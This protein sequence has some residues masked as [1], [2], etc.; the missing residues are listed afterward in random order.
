M[1]RAR[2]DRVCRDIALVRELDA[3]RQALHAEIGR[4]K[5]EQQ[6]VSH[7]VDR[8]RTLSAQIEALSDSDGQS[9][10]QVS[11]PAG[12]R[13]EL[14]TTWEQVC[15]AGPE[16]QSLMPRATAAS[17]YMTWEWMASWYETYG[18]PGRTMC[19]VVRDEDGSAVGIAPLHLSG[20]RDPSLDRRDIGF[21][22]TFG[23]ARASYHE[24][25][26]A[27]QSHETVAEATVEYLSSIDGQWDCAK[28]LWVPDS[29]DVTWYLIAALIRRGWYIHV[30]PSVTATVM[31]LP[32]HEEEVIDALSSRKFAANCRQAQQRLARD[33]PDHCFACVRDS[34]EAVACL[35]QYVN[36]NVVRR[37]GLGSSSRFLNVQYRRHFESSTRRF[38]KA[39]WLR[40]STLRV[41]DRLVG[42][43]PSWLYHNRLYLLSPAW[44]EEYARYQISHQLFLHAI[45]QGI[46]EGAKEADFLSAEQEYKRW[47]SNETRSTMD[48]LCWRSRPQ[49]LTGLAA[50]A[51]RALVAKAGRHLR[52]RR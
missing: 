3:Q 10:A 14:L 4:L 28:F 25:V 12:S 37:R 50:E 8:S 5:S 31:R 40:L 38:A 22:G 6:D 17:P 44:S 26:S 9:A 45:C 42:L 21:A 46:R 1:T 39:G 2:A 15:A 18:E 23:R 43:Q 35:D 27:P 24:F 30:R 36:L 11:A 29:S 48:I 52:L 51:A 47:Y 20:T 13:S 7:L 16:W 33:Y 49:M 32:S 34:T 41:G 19:L